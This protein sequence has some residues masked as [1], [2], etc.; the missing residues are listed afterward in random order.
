MSMSMR[1][2]VDA[3]VVIAT[4]KERVVEYRRREERS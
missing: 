4:A 3:G 1:V 2:G